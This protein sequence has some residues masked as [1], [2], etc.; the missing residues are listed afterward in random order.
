MP[1][2]SAEARAAAHY[3]AATAPHHP[4]KGLN[5][6]ARKLWRE[7]VAGKAPD[8]FDPG[9]LPLLR[10]FVETSVAIETVPVH[11]T[12]HRRMLASLVQLA[13][14]L[15]LT[16]QAAIHR[17]DGRLSERTGPGVR[18]NRHGTPCLIGGRD[19]RPGD[20]P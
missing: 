3:R 7:I 6:A 12:T 4:P 14:K 13:T 20:A 8:H 2:K 15:R 10:L 18:R 16:P 11:T 17:R 1:R 9:S 19:F 5:P